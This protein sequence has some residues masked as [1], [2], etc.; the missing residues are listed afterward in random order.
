MKW[1]VAVLT[2]FLLRIKN[3]FQ[4]G[5]SLEGEKQQLIN[6]KTDGNL[7]YNP[8]PPAFLSDLWSLMSYV[9]T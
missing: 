7:K 8:N 2:F 3:N 4:A 5:Q 6:E 9:P 1:K